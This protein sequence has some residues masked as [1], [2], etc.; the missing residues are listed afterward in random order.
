MRAADQ[1]VPARDPRSRRG[2]PAHAG[3]LFAV[4]AEQVEG[5]DGSAR[6][7]VRQHKRL[8]MEVVVNAGT[9]R[10]SPGISGQVHTNQGS[11]RGARNARIEFRQDVSLLEVS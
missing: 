3:D 1:H 7:A 8:R 9:T 2:I 5:N 10:C 11:N 4:Q 6:L